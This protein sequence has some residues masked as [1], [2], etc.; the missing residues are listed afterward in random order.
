[1]AVLHCRALTIFARLLGFF[2][3]ATR[4]TTLD[5]VGA[6]LEDNDRLRAHAASGE[7]DILCRHKGVGIWVAVMWS[8]SL[9]TGSC[10][11]V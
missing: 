6:H 3:V 4:D 2:T 10:M 5:A 1:M 11:I 9:F 7:N 8:N